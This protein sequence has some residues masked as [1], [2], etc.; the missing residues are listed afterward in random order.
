MRYYHRI[1]TFP[2]ELNVLL[3][4]FD[5]RRVFYGLFF[6]AVRDA[7]HQVSQKWRHWKAL[8]GAVAVMHT[9]SQVLGEHIPI[10]VLIPAVGLS[11]DRPGTL[12]HWA[13]ERCDW[14]RIPCGMGGEPKKTRRESWR[15]CARGAE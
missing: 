3:E 14:T 9:C 10:H 7:L 1:F 15:A 5:N 8:I 4:R 12:A 11:I 6:A 2:H 13:K